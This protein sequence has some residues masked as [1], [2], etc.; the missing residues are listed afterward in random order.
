[1]LV[2]SIALPYSQWDKQACL[3][4]DADVDADVHIDFEDEDADDHLKD[5][6]SQLIHRWWMF[7]AD[8]LRLARPHHSALELFICSVIMEL[9]QEA[10]IKLWKQEEKCDKKYHGSTSSIWH[11][12]GIF[13]ILIVTWIQYSA[14]TQYDL[15]KMWTYWWYIRYSCVKWYQFDCR[16]VVIVRCCL[17]MCKPKEQSNAM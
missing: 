16:A 14:Y 17:I 12:V 9:Y 5:I 11:E 15:A 2:D 3:D 6:Y 1:M 4:A 8:R 10:R 13:Y 7:Q